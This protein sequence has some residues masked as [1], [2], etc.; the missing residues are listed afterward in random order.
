MTCDPRHRYLVTIYT[1]A[2]VTVDRDNAD[3]RVE[4]AWRP[5][6]I[7]KKDAAADPPPTEA[8]RRRP[9]R[10]KMQSLLLKMLN[11]LVRER[12][13][14]AEAVSVLTGGAFVSIRLLV[15]P[16]AVPVIMVRCERIGVGNVSGSVWVCPLE[17][18]M[19]PPPSDKEEVDAFCLLNGQVT[20]DARVNGDGASGSGAKVLDQETTVTAAMEADETRT[21]PVEEVD[22]VSDSDDDEEDD[23]AEKKS[24]T[25]SI[26]LPLLSLE[27]K[28]K[29]QQNIIDARLEWKRT[30]SR[31]RVLQVIE[32]VTAGASFTFDYALFVFC[33]AFIA[34]IG[35]ATDSGPTVIASMLVSPIMGP[36]MVRLMD[37]N[38]CVIFCRQKIPIFVL[39]L[40]ARE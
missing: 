11:R 12:V 22:E 17:T 19:M 33:A 7:K 2:T 25:G 39:I 30:S 34:A 38:I 36:V 8:T 6:I 21:F 40:C 24:A 20:G 16:S 26:R 23:E 4:K 15:A 10:V 9:V 37:M 29:L 27:K 35:L 13:I 3:E 31:V 14:P 28:K 5:Y 18:S 32:E 1:R